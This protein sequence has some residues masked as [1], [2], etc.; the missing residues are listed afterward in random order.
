MPTD[1]DKALDSL[2]RNMILLVELLLELPV[3]ADDD[4]EVLHSIIQSFQRRL[5]TE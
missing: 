3:F 5:G 2:S 1:P 4:R